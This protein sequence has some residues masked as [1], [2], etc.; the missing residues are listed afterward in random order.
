[1]PEGDR[2]SPSEKASKLQPGTKKKGND[3]AIWIVKMASNGTHRWI[4]LSHKQPA[5]RIKII[6][7][8][9]ITSVVEFENKNLNGHGKAI[10]SRRKSLKETGLEK[11]A[12]LDMDTWK[13]FKD[14]DQDSVWLKP[15]RTIRYK[16]AFIGYDPVSKSSGGSAVLLE[17]AKGRYVCVSE[18]IWEFETIDKENIDS[19]TAPMG[20]NM[21]P[22]PYASTNEHVYL[23]IPKPIAVR[24]ELLER[25][26]DACTLASGNKREC[27]DPYMLFWWTDDNGKAMSKTSP[28]M[29]KK[30]TVELK[31][32]TLL[33][34][35]YI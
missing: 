27:N 24:Q 30:R 6:D 26:R 25:L 5:H 13:L 7:N 9:S 16:K 35:R 10:V 23:T 21:V 12:F 31:R 4:R 22:Y 28:Q 29:I 17:T 34:P 2:P 14:R 18:A 20:K 19:F 1:M 3:G 11:E 33:C 15:W 32:T 8:G